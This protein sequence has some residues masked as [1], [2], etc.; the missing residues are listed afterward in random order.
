VRVTACHDDN[1]DALIKNNDIYGIEKE[2]R[3]G[4]ISEQPVRYSPEDD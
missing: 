3:S 1:I 4:E 2:S